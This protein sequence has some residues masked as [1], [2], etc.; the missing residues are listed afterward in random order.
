[1]R[2]DDE[3]VRE[4]K[5]L[6]RLCTL[7]MSTNE[8]ERNTYQCICITEHTLSTSVYDCTSTIITVS[9]DKMRHVRVHE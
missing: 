7:S 6:G 3:L 8:N 1:M 5:Q 9:N 4:V 2:R